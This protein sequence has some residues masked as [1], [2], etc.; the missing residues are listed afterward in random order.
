MTVLLDAGV[1]YAFYDRKDSWHERTVKLFRDEEGPLIIPSPVIPEVDHALAKR[2]LQGAQM[3]LYRSLA[4]GDFLVVDLPLEKYGRVEELNRRFA[5]LSLGF[6]D[7]AVV[8]ISEVIGV[9]RVAT[10]D[11]RDF[12]PLAAAFDLE[13]LP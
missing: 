2:R 7:A 8:V 6:V 9:R 13:L 12:A 5:D 1:L 3:T 4:T 11:R 10:T